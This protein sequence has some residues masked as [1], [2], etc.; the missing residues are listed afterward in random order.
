[1][2]RTHVPVL[3]GLSPESAALISRVKRVRDAASLHVRVTAGTP[4]PFDY[5]AANEAQRDDFIRRATLK[6]FTVEIVE[7]A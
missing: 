1:M 5:Y 4:E 6:G 3:A 2:T 7:R